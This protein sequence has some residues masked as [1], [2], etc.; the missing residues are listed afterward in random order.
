MALSVGGNPLSDDDSESVSRETSPCSESPRPLS[1]HGNDDSPQRVQQASTGS[2]FSPQLI[3]QS[4]ISPMTTT[5]S[6]STSTDGII[7]ISVQGGSSHSMEPTILR[8][9][10]IISTSPDGTVSVSSI[11]SSVTM[12]N[13]SKVSSGQ[14][15]LFTGG[16]S[17][18]LLRYLFP[19]VH[20]H[21]SHSGA[22]VNGSKL[23]YAG[24]PVGLW[25]VGRRIRCFHC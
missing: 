6:T 25:D 8:N 22:P 24:I 14:S 18:C 1:L 12:R 10:N 19:I 13:K 23:D 5:S 21:Y 15:V 17:I 4:A 2:Q 7:G 9:T 11:T 20:W 16:F 3:E